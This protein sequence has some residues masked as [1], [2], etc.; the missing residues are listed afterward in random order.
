MGGDLRPMVCST[1]GYIVQIASELTE[2]AYR[3]RIASIR[4][5]NQ[6]PAGAHYYT[7]DE[8]CN[9]YG[10]SGDFW[11]LYAG[12]FLRPSDACPS[13]LQSPPDAFIKGLRD[14]NRQHTLQCLCES[15]VEGI[16]QYE[17]L[18]GRDSAWTGEL[19]QALRSM[20]YPV[21]QKDMGAYSEQTRH[22]VAKFQRIVSLPPSGEVD[23]DTWQ[24]LKTITCT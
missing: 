10:T 22:I 7:Q 13:R 16:P 6:L 19:Q 11:V 18:A 15:A 23:S 21:D 5:A 14:D 8:D 9:S 4:V 3:D 2:Q 24:R 20:G 17:S 12:P 1:A